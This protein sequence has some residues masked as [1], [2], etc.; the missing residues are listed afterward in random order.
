M[1]TQALACAIFAATALSP[2]LVIASPLPAFA[3]NE[4]EAMSAVKK[5]L[6]SSPKAARDFSQDMHDIMPRGHQPIVFGGTL[7]PP[8]ALAARTVSSLEHL[9]QTGAHVVESRDEPRRGVVGTA[10]MPANRL[11]PRDVSERALDADTAG[12]NAYSGSAGDVSGGSTGSHSHFGST[13]FPRTDDADTMGGNA[14]TGS[15]GDVS[16]GSIENIASNDGMPT[17]MNINSNNAGA[18]GTSE[19]GCSAGGYSSDASHG[20]NGD[21]GS[22]ASNGAGGNAYSGSTGGAEGG[23]VNNVGGMVNMDSNNAGAA[24]TSASG[25]AT[26]GNVGL[27]NKNGTQEKVRPDEDY[28]SLW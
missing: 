19:S 24:G 4:A 3:H 6:P 26:G 7:Q 21:S 20:T 22:D 16:G 17:L 5:F 25:C 10:V 27:K 23:S 11:G 13:H 28:Y 12:G 15:T 18:G 2:S 9:E 8:H 1:R 14:Y